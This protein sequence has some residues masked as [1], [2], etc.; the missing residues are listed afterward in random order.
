MNFDEVRAASLEKYAMLEDFVDEKDLFPIQYDVVTTDH[1]TPLK[2][3]IFG[4][5]KIM[6]FTD[7]HL[8]TLGKQTC[9]CG[10]AVK[11]GEKYMLF[12]KRRVVID[13]GWAPVDISFPLEAF[14]F[15]DTYFWCSQTRVRLAYKVTMDKLPARETYCLQLPP[16][17]S[18]NENMS[19]CPYTRKYTFTLSRLNYVTEL[20]FLR[21]VDFVTLTIG[22]AKKT[23]TKLQMLPL[24]KTNKFDY[25]SVPVCVNTNKQ[26]V[27]VTTSFIIHEEI[28]VI[29]KNYING[30]RTMIYENDKHR[31]LV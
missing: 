9:E 2:F 28:Y 26:D 19:Q 25:L 8:L 11:T 21:D 6:S 31:E 24:N 1:F 17:I 15:R 29:T 27:V 3:D 7:A 4:I 22:S 16:E 5:K 30:G 13:G 23:Y 18:I 20:R 10:I 14:A 12:Y